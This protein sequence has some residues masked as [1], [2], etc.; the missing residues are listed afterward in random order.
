MSL[1][2][3]HNLKPADAVY[4][5]GMHYL[6]STQHSDGSWRVKSRSPEIQTYFESG[7]PYGRDQWISL[8]GTAW[9]TTALALAA[10]GR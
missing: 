2:E 9:A 7:F 3:S 8:A 5:Q 4:R 1:V 10:E 6:L